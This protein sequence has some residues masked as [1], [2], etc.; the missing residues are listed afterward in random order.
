[1]ATFSR[2]QHKHVHVRRWRITPPPQQCRRPAAQH[3]LSPE[4]IGWGLFFTPGL[5]ALV[6]SAIKGNGNVQD[7]FSHLITLL[8]QG[9]LQPDAGGKEIP[10]AEGDLSE[11]T[12]SYIGFLYNQYV[13]S[14]RFNLACYLPYDSNNFELPGERVFLLAIV[15]LSCDC[16]L[17][18]V[19]YMCYAILLYIYDVSCILTVTAPGCKQS[20]HAD[21]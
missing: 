8:S 3:A 2:C 13:F 12:G 20:Y 19:L 9:Y 17:H 14:L 15:R 1:M 16:L 6:Y 21:S 7:G 11:F 10:V 18:K 5:A 4:A